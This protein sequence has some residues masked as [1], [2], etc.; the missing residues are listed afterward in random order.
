M[1]GLADLIYV[2]LH[3]Y[4]NLWLTA[5]VYVGFLGLCV[6]GLCGWLADHRTTTDYLAAAGGS[7]A[8]EATGQ[9]SGSGPNATS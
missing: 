3:A 5:M 1:V 2:R 7:S 9:P 8:D 4:K 6:L